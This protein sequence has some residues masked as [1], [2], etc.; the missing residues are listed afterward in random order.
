MTTVLVTGGT[1]KTGRRVVRLLRERGVPVRVGSRTGSPAFDW[2]VPATWAQ[3]LD[4]TG[5]VYLCY[6]PDLAFPG[7]VDTV[8]AFV[9]QAVKQGVRRIVLL[10]GRGEPACAAAERVVRDSGVAWTVV[11]A[12]FFAQNFS[13]AFFQP[14][15]VAGEIVLPVGDAPEPFV[16]ADDIAEVATVA[17]TEGGHDGRTYEVTG[18]RLL[19][20]A[21]VAAELTAATGREIRFTP[22][23]REDYLEALRAEGLP[24]EFADLF[25]MVTDGRNAYLA[26]GVRHALGREP[27]DFRDYARAAAATGVWSAA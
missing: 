23:T 5:A 25:Q 27:R 7:A 11:R 8:G 19:S 15:V 1:G 20:F 12:S 9:E 6:Q 2:A 26:Y 3:A 14:A 13:E 4:G 24:E 21:E 17:L 22:V 10:S 16:D 18:P